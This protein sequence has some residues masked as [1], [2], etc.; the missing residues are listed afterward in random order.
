MYKLSFE[1]VLWFLCECLAIQRLRR[2]P[3]RHKYSACN[4]YL[5]DLKINKYLFCCY[6]SY[7]C[8]CCLF[9]FS[10]LFLRTTRLMMPLS[11]LLSTMINYI[12]F[13][14]LYS[15]LP[16]I[17]FRRRKQASQFERLLN[18]HW[19]QT[20][21][22]VTFRRRSMYKIFVPF[23]WLS[24]IIFIFILHLSDFLRDV[25]KYDRLQWWRAEE[26]ITTR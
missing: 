8:S 19:P 11:L 12:I 21:A 18:R 17:G 14:S 3:W 10:T 22:F 2:W 26:I 16:P 13:F 23:S 7:C 1:I 5:S 24:L 20:F 9:C 15:Q 6:C 25:N 4:S